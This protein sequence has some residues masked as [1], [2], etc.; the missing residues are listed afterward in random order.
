M[1]AGLN[2]KRKNA[3]DKE[4]PDEYDPTDRK[5]GR[6]SKGGEALRAKRYYVKN[7]LLIL[8][9][10]KL[11]RYVLKVKKILSD[12]DYDIEAVKSGLDKSCNVYRLRDNKGAEMDSILGAVNLGREDHYLSFLN[13]EAG[14]ELNVESG[15]SEGMKTQ[16]EETFSDLANKHT[17]R[18][19]QLATLLSAYLLL[20]YARKKISNEDIDVE[21]LKKICLEEYEVSYNHLTGEELPE[22][23]IKKEE[24]TG[25]PSN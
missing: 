2:R 13:E 25:L 18:L 21:D 12:N 9:K 5:V 10:R 7:H 11:R 23:F 14:K 24:M 4:V 1:I 3:V 6:P 15:Y 17:C 16:I 8:Q 22:G 20:N 19:F